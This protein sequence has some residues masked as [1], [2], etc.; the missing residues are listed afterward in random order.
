MINLHETMFILKCSIQYK[1]KNYKNM[2]K[3]FPHPN[4]FV[5]QNIN[6]P[7]DTKLGKLLKQEQFNGGCRTSGGK[8]AGTA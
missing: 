1:A 4:R 7:N 5:P 2:N 8:S 6:R 3:Y